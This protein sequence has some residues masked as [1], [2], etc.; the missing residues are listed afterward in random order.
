MS[1]H[2]PSKELIIAVDFD[3]TIVEHDFPHIGKLMPD[4]KNVINKLHN[5]GHKIIVWTCRNNTEPRYP[6]WI[7]APVRSVMKF[8]EKSGI[9][10][11][12]INENHPDMGFWLDSRKVFA[13]IYIDDRNIGGFPGWMASYDMIQQYLDEG[14][15]G[16][17]AHIWNYRH[18]DV[19]STL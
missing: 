11:D 3:G 6:D 13:D 12:C 4:A 15:W 9:H 10:F 7:D 2:Q 17:V 5:D 16:G 19:K 1:T 18:N 8:L 14:D